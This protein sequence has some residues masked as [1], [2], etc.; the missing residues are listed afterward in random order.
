AFLSLRP[1]ESVIPLKIAHA[2]QCPCT[3]TAS[4]TPRIPSYGLVHYLPDDG[5]N[6]IGLARQDGSEF[7]GRHEEVAMVRVCKAEG[8]DAMEREIDGVVGIRV[9][10][11]PLQA[12]R[13]RLAQQLGQFMPRRCLRL[14]RPRYDFQAKIHDSVGAECGIDPIDI[15]MC[16]FTNPLEVHGFEWYSKLRH[17]RLQRRVVYVA[18]R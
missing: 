16:R 11:A 8:L 7:F 9:C 14:S 13:R 12:R 15:L 6:S 18:T 17:R 1:G 5:G 3:R 4:L 10:R 2:Q